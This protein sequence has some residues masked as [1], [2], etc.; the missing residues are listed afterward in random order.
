MAVI[1]LT[2]VAILGYAMG[3][4]QIRGTDIAESLRLPPPEPPLDML[5]DSSMNTI[6]TSSQFKFSAECGLPLGSDWDIPGWGKVEVGFQLLPDG[7][8]QI[9]A[10]GTQGST[11]QLMR[12]KV[13]CLP[14][15]PCPAWMT[16]EQC[17]G[18]GGGAATVQLTSC[19]P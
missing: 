10:T 1:V 7:F 19:L 8:F 18:G 16:P 12:C 4:L 9:S 13:I 15:V 2:C 3:R 17:A 11:T 6:L 5:I 14:G